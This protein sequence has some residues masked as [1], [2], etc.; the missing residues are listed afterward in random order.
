MYPT[1][2]LLRPSNLPPCHHRFPPFA[3]AFPAAIAPPL[4]DFPATQFRAQPLRSNFLAAS[5]LHSTATMDAVETDKSGSELVEVGYVSSVHGVHGEICLQPS[6]DFA[7][8]RLAT[9]GR[10]WLKQFV[11]GQEVIKEVELMEGWE[12]PGKKSWVL[13][14]AGLDTVDEARQLIGSTLLA[15]EDD[16]PELE[17]GEFYTRDLIGMRVIFKDT[18]TCIGTVVDVYDSGASEILRV[19]LYPSTEA[20]DATEKPVPEE[21]G[22]VSGRLVWIPFVEAIVPDVD[23]NKREMWITPPK[24]LLELNNRSNEMSKKERRQIEWKEKKKS[25]RQLIAAKKKLS[26]MEQKH[27][28]DGLRYGEKSQKSLLADDIVAAN[29]D[30]L[31]QALKN[32]GVSSN[33]WNTSE[34]VSETRAKLK[35]GS[36]KISRDQLT[37]A[38]VNDLGATSRFHENGCHLVFEGKI[39]IV[40]VVNNLNNKGADSHHQLVD[41]KS[42][43]T[44]TSPC[45]FISKALSDAQTFVKLEDRGSIPLV[46][47]CPEQQIE[48]LKE[49][50]TGND[51]FAFDCDKVWFLEE[52]KLPVVTSSSDENCRNEI[53]MKS[54][55]EILKAPVG[56]GGVIQSLSSHN[57]SDALSEMGVKY[58]EVCSTSSMSGIWTPT[59]PGLVDIQGADVGVQISQDL[60]QLEETFDIV[61][62]VEFAKSLANQMDKLCFEAIPKANTH[63]R[64]VEK[65][66]VDIV[67]PSS[68]PN[69]YELRC[70]IYSSINACPLDKVSMMEITE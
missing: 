37:C 29:S 21:T 16:R 33:R 18:S 43:H 36:L 34:F 62:S 44:E 6:T 28:F 31:Q 42:S 11:Y 51:F 30:L 27:V 13:T 67:P 39:A 24:G 47:V 53:L 7:E 1:V 20:S 22:S 5:P 32:I 12:K 4:L 55:W 41:A 66:W 59:F 45:S 17:E 64:L 35:N 9:P 40:L 60:T 70:S 50:F 52:E 48:P 46:L 23:M 49:L 25:Q 68:S 63:I 38:S 26:D 2:S 61:F 65:E 54:P 3:A 19:M 56:S 15:R 14:L 8:L 10:R 57:I 58:I 69:S